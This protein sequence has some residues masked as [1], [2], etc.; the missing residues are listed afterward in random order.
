MSVEFKDDN[1]FAADLNN[2]LLEPIG[3]SNDQKPRLLEVQTL[4]ED[5]YADLS[6]LQMS[7]FRDIFLS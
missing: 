7:L 3:S 5:D 2:F 1:N 4:M 6:A